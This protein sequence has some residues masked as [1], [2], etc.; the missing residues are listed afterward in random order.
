MVTQT[1]ATACLCTLTAGSRLKGYLS[2][3]PDSWLLLR[4][5]HVYGFWPL[6]VMQI[7]ADSCTLTAGSY[8]LLLKVDIAL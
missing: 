3:Y 4:Q 1:A 5:L 8:M 6:V 2:M 7:S